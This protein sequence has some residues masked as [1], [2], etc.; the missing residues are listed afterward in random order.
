MTPKSPSLKIDRLKQILGLINSR[1][2]ISL[3]ELEK[4]LHAPR[5]TVQ[6][7]L[8][9]LE[10]RKLIR[11]FH[12]GAMSID[13][14]SDFYNYD[15]KKSVQVEAKKN[16]AAKANKL[17]HEKAAI[18]LDS[19]STVYYLSETIFPANMMVLA[20]SID[21]FRNLSSREDV[22]VV[23]AGGRL[24][25]KTA[26][27]YGP[28]MI[29]MIRQFHF[30]YAFISAEAFIPGRGFFDPH[31]E[32]VAVKH[33]LIESSEKTVMMIDTSKVK[34]GSGIRVCD[35][36]DIDFVVT[37]NPGTSPLRKIFKNRLL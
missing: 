17:L 28:E 8:V 11:R 3:T 26:T 13:F 33:A 5:I 22:Q 15:Q 24:H 6:R 2:R 14:S 18:C 25:R 21:A 31:E 34:T 9:E 29:A 37:D 35:S 30:D 4:T 20:S 7:D 1:K 16:I 12:G 27:F 19:S 32:A 23:F 10:N 36:D